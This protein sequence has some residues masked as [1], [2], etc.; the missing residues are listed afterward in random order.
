LFASY[1]SSFALRKI[2][3]MASTHTTPAAFI[4]ISV[5]LPTLGTITVLLR[6]YTRVKAE[7]KLGVDD[8]LTIPALVR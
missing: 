4:L 1:K 5:L 6:F 8:W 3:T 2:S 7:I